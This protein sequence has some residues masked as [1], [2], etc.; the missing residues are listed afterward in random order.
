MTTTA[1][2]RSNIVPMAFFLAFLAITAA[3]TIVAR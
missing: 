1:A 3:A 2:R